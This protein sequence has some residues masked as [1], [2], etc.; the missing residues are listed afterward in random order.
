MAL[1][2]PVST[3]EA[4]EAIGPYSQAIRSGSLLFCSGQIPLELR[5]KQIEEEATY[6]ELWKQLVSAVDTDVDTAMAGLDRWKARHPGIHAELGWHELRPGRD[7]GAQRAR[8]P[9][10]R[11]VHGHVGGA[12]EK[13]RLARDG[14]AVGQFAAVAHGAGGLD[15]A[16][17]IEIEH[18]LGL[19]LVAGLGVVAGQAQEV[20]HAAGGRSHEIGLQCDAVTVAAGE[21]EYGLDALARQDRRRDRR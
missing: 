1:R 4:P 16:A 21:L 8:A 12:D 5:A 6:G 15:Q 17:G 2:M 13:P 3:D 14:L 18:R 20:A 19:R 11:W 7:L 10:G 9:V